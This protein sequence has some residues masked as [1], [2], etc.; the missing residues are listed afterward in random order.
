LNVNANTPSF[1]TDTTSDETAC[2]KFL[3]YLPQIEWIFISRDS[4]AANELKRSEFA[5]RFRSLARAPK[6]ILLFTILLTLKW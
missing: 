4:G 6:M 2:P 5:N 1:F 3:G